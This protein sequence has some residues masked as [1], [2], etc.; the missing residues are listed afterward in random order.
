MHSGNSGKLSLKP[1]Q[2]KT[3][4]QKKFQIPLCSM[5]KSKIGSPQD[6]MLSCLLQMRLIKICQQNE[7]GL[8][9]H[10]HYTRVLELG[11]L[12]QQQQSSSEIAKSCLEQTQSGATGSSQW[13]QHLMNCHQIR[14]SFSSS[15]SSHTP[16]QYLYTIAVVVLL[17]PL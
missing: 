12:V 17:L 9:K 4:I 1:L 16:L 7:K 14:I 13:Y 6:L 8:L 15:S 2:P 5:N 10:H 3:M 11:Y